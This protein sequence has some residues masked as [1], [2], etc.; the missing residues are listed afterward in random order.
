MTFQILIFFGGVL[1][2]IPFGMILSRKLRD[3]RRA[4]RRTRYNDK[5]QEQLAEEKGD[6]PW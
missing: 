4:A 1:G 2:G 3:R 6:W 5:V